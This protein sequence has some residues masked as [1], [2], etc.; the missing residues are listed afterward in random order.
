[1][2]TILL[3]QSGF[4]S[5]AETMK[6]VSS[7]S[8]LALEIRNSRY[9]VSLL[10]N[11]VEIAGK[12]KVLIA[13]SKEKKPYAKAKFTNSIGQ[14]FVYIKP[15]SY[16]MGSNSEEYDEEP[17]HK[18]TLTKGFHM[19]TTEVTQGQWQDVMKTKPWSGKEY[20]KESRD[21]PAVYV[22]WN[23]IK[24]FISRLNSLDGKKYR[25][26]TEAE[27]EY[28][29]RAGSLS[30]YCFGD[31]EYK[32][33]EY[34]WYSKNTWDFGEKYSHSVGTKKPNQWGLYDMHGNVWEWCED[35]YGNKYYSTSSEID[36]MG[37]SSGTFRVIRGG[38]WFNPSR[39]SRSADRARFKPE[40]RYINAGFRLV[41][42]QVR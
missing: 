39:R 26:P 31:S 9:K 4:S 11:P 24:E 32:L 19:Q 5:R 35:W 37:P 16:T 1:M 40:F 18:V 27:W 34:A 21:N 10:K 36:P 38:C 23:D 28:A 33:G 30:K 15:G 20:V 12:D 8:K 6:R 17:A 42:L 2:L 41:F 3:P 13:L 7:Q 29:A 25:L 14:R 22:S